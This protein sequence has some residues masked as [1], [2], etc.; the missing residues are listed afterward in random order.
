MFEY[1]FVLI[2]L[3]THEC[4]RW[5]H[6]PP[7]CKYPLAGKCGGLGIAVRVKAE[8]LKHH[9]EAVSKRRDIKHL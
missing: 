1:S 8:R 2:V 5:R 3:S 6:E 9:K 4:R 7:P